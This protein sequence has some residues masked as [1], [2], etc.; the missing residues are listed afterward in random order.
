[1]TRPDRIATRISRDD[2]A[3]IR[4]VVTDAFDQPDEASIVDARREALAPCAPG[5]EW[6]DRV[7]A[8]VRDLR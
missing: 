8:G 6:R 3:T 5:L 1:M 4:D 2:V 7:P